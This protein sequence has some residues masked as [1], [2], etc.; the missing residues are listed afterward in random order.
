MNMNIPPQVQVMRVQPLGARPPTHDFAAAASSTEP[1]YHSV[2]CNRLASPGRR[3]DEE[4]LC[5]ITEWLIHHKQRRDR[6][7]PWSSQQRDHP[8]RL[9][10]WIVKCVASNDGLSMFL[11][12]GWLVMFQVTHNIPHCW[13]LLAM[14]S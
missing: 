1:S 9:S 12:R 7:A 2:A 6:K 14:A 10:C 4:P 3:R 8:E 13:F 11:S 5:Q